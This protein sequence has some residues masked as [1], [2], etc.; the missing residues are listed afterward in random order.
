MGEGNLEVGR[1]LYQDVRTWESPFWSF[2][3]YPG[4]TGAVGNLNGIL[5]YG[6]SFD[7]ETLLSHVEPWVC[8]STLQS[9]Y[10]DRG[11]IKK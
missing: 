2:G 10:Q 3:T 4:G 7:E 8:G 6:L 5:L 9:G 1:S 11:C